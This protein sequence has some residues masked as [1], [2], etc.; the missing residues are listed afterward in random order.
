MPPEKPSEP[1]L[2]PP[3]GEREKAEARRWF[4]KARGLVETRNYDYAIECYINGLTC[5]PEA[6]EEGHKPLYY[7]AL[8]RAAAG[9]KKPGTLETIRHPTTGKDPRKAMLNA[10]LLMAK[11]PKNIGYLEALFRNAA[12]ARLDEVVMWAGPLFLDAANAEKKPSPQRFR[13]IVDT[14][15]ELAD[16]Q[17]GA[18]NVSVGIEAYE[19]AI[20]AIS[21]LRQVDPKDLDLQREQTELATRLTI[22]RGKYETAQTFKESV[23]DASAQRDIHDAE[24]VVQADERLDELISKARAEAA[25]NPDVPAKIM[26][27]VDLLCKREDERY[28][29]EAVQTLMA[30]YSKTD[31]YLFKVRADDIRIRQLGRK[32]RQAR[33]AGDR[34]AARQLYLEQLRLELEVYRERV[35]HYP[36]D[37]RMR[38]E[39]GRRL[40]RARRYDEAIPLFQEARNDPKS[41]IP[42]HLYIGQ[43]FFEKGY[44]DQAVSVL[45]EGINSYEIQGDELSKEM[46]YWLARA[47]EDAG[48][49]DDARKVYGQILQWDYNYK[50]VR[51]RMDKL[52]VK[53]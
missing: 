19:R 43:C 39:Y 37:L 29:N 18:G 13:L 10:E 4:E 21:R 8:K 28:E 48:R 27:L 47:H 36:T 17:A 26:R 31:N 38:F 11:D 7:A 42:C 41:R 22:L 35:E 9:G 51:D 23:R 15:A 6:I 30:A 53:R 25:A 33:A 2:P 32:V 44:H 49:L 12:R 24:R 46:H 50:D 45:Q 5:W 20:Q 1:P 34:E 52:R 14:Y 16:R 40:F 3:T